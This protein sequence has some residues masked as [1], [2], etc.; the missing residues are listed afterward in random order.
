MSNSPALSVIVPVYNVS[1]YIEKCAR[2]VFEQSLDDLEIIFVN[3]CSTDN[4]VEIIE[5]VISD[6]A[7]TQKKSRIVHMPSNS[8]LPAVR[9]Q[10]IIHATGDF[11]IHLDG[12]DWV[13][14]DYYKSLYDKALETGADIVVGDEVMEYPH[15][16]VPKN[17]DPLP[18]LGKEIMRN[19]YRRTIGLFCHNKLVKR[20][21]YTDNDVLPWEGLNMWEDN[22]LFAR[23]FYYAD[24]IAQAHGPVYHYNRCNVGAMTA[25]YGISQVNQMIGVAKNLTV[26][27]ESKPDAEDFSKT[28]QAF[29]YLAKLNLIT[30]SYRN[31]SL[32]KETFPG[33]DE[34]ASELDKGA[35]SSKGKIRFFFAKHHLSFVFVTLFK[36]KNLIGRLLDKNS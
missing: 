3:D 34:I 10:G 17:N 8:G 16:S 25:G 23:L 31:L 18:G 12:D 11:V 28:V 36:L 20:S 4:S 14:T 35:F 2:S 29:Q 19:W 15:R 1:A 24:K 30:D 33:S 27:F 6:Y 32:F 9:R 7:H 5:K 26:F 21:I 13:D 22:G